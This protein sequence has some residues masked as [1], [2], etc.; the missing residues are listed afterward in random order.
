MMASG[1]DTCHSKEQEVQPINDCKACHDALPGLHAK[2]GHP[3]ASCTDCHTPHVWKAT[4]R[5]HCLA[6]HDDKKDHYKDGG[7]CASCHE[8]AGIA[9]SARAAAEAVTAHGA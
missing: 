9:K 8:F 4:G 5:D 2:G 7:D 1:C 3:D 6:C